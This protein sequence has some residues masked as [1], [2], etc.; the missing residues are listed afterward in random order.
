RRRGRQPHPPTTRAP[1]LPL[2][3]RQQRRVL[4][5]AVADP[6]DQ[7]HTRVSDTGRPPAA[8]VVFADVREA[9]SRLAGEG[10]RTPVVT[11]E[12]LD[13][14]AGAEVFLKAENLQKVGAFKAR[15]ALNA[16]LSL[17]PDQAARGV[18]A[19]SS[20]NHAAALAFAGRR[21]GIPVQVVMP[22]NAPAA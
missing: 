11:S 8:D 6:A 19:H 15:G 12:S 10:H 4:R 5:P 1:R 18:A 21:G 20:G 17:P 3:Q 16:V 9:A 13:R 7:A 22:A 14:W 2:L